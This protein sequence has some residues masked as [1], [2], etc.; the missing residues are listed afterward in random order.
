MSEFRVDVLKMGSMPLR[1]LRSIASGEKP[2]SSSRCTTPRSSSAIR[3]DMSSEFAFAP[4][5]CES[6][7]DGGL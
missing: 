4:P 6:T 7:V 5:P 1:S 3:V 2:T